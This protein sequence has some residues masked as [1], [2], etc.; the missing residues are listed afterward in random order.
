MKK[1]VIPFGSEKHQHASG[2]YFSA[3]LCR[4]HSHCYAKS[5]ND[6]RNRSVRN[7]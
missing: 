2:S 1:T 4:A 5:E 3:H 6:F 7:T